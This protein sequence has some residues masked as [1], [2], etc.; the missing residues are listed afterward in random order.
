M[1]SVGGVW[2]HP[3]LGTFSALGCQNPLL[4]QAGLSPCWKAP[5]VSRCPQRSQPSIP[6]PPA[7][8]LAALPSLHPPSLL[9]L[10]G[11][12]RSPQWG[13]RERISTGCSEEGSPSPQNPPAQLTPRGPPYPIHPLHPIHPKPHIPRPSQTSAPLPHQQPWDPP[14]HCF[15]PQPDIAAPKNKTRGF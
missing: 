5:P 10:H 8:L 11:P 7:V 13:R 12:Q 1:G 14:A 2:L 3:S 4:Y 15:P 6:V 9:P